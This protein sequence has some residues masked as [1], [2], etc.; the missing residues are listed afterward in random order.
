MVR[1]KLRGRGF[2]E[3][4]GLYGLA[5][6]IC[7]DPSINRNGIDGHAVVP[8]D[9]HYEITFYAEQW[10]KTQLIVAL[11]NFLQKAVEVIA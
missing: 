4:F 2:P 9:N 10:Q 6:T 3:R 1:S 11:V 5:G 7:L 8:I